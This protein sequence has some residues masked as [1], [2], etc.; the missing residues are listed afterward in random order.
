MKNGNVEQKRTIYLFNQIENKLNDSDRKTIFDTT[1]DIYRNNTIDLGKIINTLEI[2][3]GFIDQLFTNNLL[4]NENIE[5]QSIKRKKKK[6]R[7]EPK[8]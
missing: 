1:K 4:E 3:T 8:R 5:E 6:R 2:S 7:R